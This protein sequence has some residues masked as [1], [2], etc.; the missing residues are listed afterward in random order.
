[1]RP[2]DRETLAEDLLT[3]GRLLFANQR[4]SEAVGTLRRATEKAP[5]NPR[6]LMALAR[7][8]DD[9]CQ[10]H[11]AEAVY[12]RLLSLEPNNAEVH[13][14]LGRVYLRQDHCWR[15]DREFRRALRLEP[16]AETYRDIGLLELRRNRLSKA[17]SA[18]R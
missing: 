9:L 14:L 15:A 12:R 8:Y 17:L 18:F 1:M 4:Y 7:V 6:M 10:D 13:R 5:K 16:N 2:T 3:R 11:E